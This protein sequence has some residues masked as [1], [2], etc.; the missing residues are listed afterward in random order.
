M[1]KKIEQE[2][3]KKLNDGLLLGDPLGRKWKVWISTP[4]GLTSAREARTS[5]AEAAERVL[6]ILA[7]GRQ[8]RERRRA[9]GIRARH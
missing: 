3:S 6:G 1:G 5:L 9:R 4:P 7:A 2:N 8:M